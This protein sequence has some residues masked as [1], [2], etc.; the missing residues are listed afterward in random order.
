MPT[1]EHILGF[2]NQWYKPAIQAA[3]TIL[4]AGRKVRLVTPVYF[5][6][7][8]L[9]AFHGRGESDLPLSQDL[10]DIIIVVDGRPEL[11]VE[12]KNSATDVRTYIVIEARQLLSRRDFSDAVSGFLLPD[13]ASQD[14]R[15]IV[16]ARL[17][18]ISRL[19]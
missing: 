1:D 13:A 4:V 8:K 14:R 12:I 3:D 17:L 9:A 11:V 7:T 10:E 6:A 19:I 15:S 5:V 2:S 18:E 16:E